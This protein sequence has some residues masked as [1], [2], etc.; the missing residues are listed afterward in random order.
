MTEADAIFDWAIALSREIQRVAKI[1][2]ERRG[3]RRKRKSRERYALRKR[4]GTLP[5]KKKAAPVERDY[6]PATSCQCSTCRMPPCSWCENG[7][8]GE[9]A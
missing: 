1:K 4:L 2:A 6:E 9:E 5:V 3:E 8:D 7:G